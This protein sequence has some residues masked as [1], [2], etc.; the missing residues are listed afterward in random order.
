MESLNS[1]I[2]RNIAAI[3]AVLDCVKNPR[4][5]EVPYGYTVGCAWP[6]L[7]QSYNDVLMH[8]EVILQ[9]ECRKSN[10]RRIAR[11]KVDPTKKITSDYWSRYPIS[12]GVVDSAVATRIINYAEKESLLREYPSEPRENCDPGTSIH[13][14]EQDLHCI[15]SIIA[16]FTAPQT[17]AQPR[18]EI[19]NGARSFPPGPINADVTDVNVRASLEARFKASLERQ[20]D[21]TLGKILIFRNAPNTVPQRFAVKTIDPARVKSTASLGAIQRF[22]HELRHWITYRHSPLIVAPLFTEFVH[23]WPYVAMPYCECTLRQYIDKQ[24]RQRDPAEA[25]ALMIECVSAL[26]YAGRHGLLAHQ[27]LKPEN[28][29]LD[30]FSRK[31]VLPDDY[32]FTSP[33]PEHF[34]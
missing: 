9:A 23:G 33:I 15:K 26:M 34:C 30:D 3:G 25:I 1:Q 14:F 8:L 21:G 17:E 5:P 28:V 27:D 7:R 29:L 13:E 10:A 19:T 24:V 12:P 4:L 6:L 32:P 31:F 22:H 11:P 2:E 20:I 16:R 18:C